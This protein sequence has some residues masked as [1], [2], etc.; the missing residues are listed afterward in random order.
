MFSP[1]IPV[2]LG[3][4]PIIDV[5]FELRFKGQTGAGGILPGLLFS[6]L[7]GVEGIDA[8]PASQL[9][10]QIRAADPDLR[11]VA[12]N[13][14]QWGK[15]AVMVGQNNIGVGCKLPYAGWREYKPAILEVLS[16]LVDVALV[17]QVERCAL[18]Y[19]NMFEG[20]GSDNAFNTFNVGLRIGSVEIA[21]NNS[22]IRVE[23][24]IGRFLHAVNIATEAKIKFQS[25]GVLKTGALLDVDS[26]ALGL[27]IS[28]G[29]FVKGAS[30]LLEDLHKAN[31]EVFFGCLTS[32]GLEK[33]E[34]QYE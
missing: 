21:G 28:I 12:T 10:E 4:E 16:H 24:P 33:L 1:N 8:L 7:K 18:K 22:Q 23:L 17:G 3:R 20:T 6:R 25:T 19:V 30:D 27:D 2:K 13:R 9:P 5:V 29:E 14:L 31:H 11:Y 26:M 34:P 32:E 15:Y